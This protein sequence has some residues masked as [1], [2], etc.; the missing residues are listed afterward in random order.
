MRSR[1]LPAALTALV[2]AL[3]LA[4]AVPAT[5]APGKAEAVNA[6]SGKSGKKVTFKKADNG[7]AITSYKWLTKNKRRLDVS[8]KSKGLGNKTRK[9]RLL[10]PKGWKFK[11][12][13]TWPVVYLLHGGG[14]A[15][16]KSWTRS[17]QIATLAAKWNAIVVMPEG[18]NGSYTNWYNNGKGGP[19]EW[20]TFHM[21]EVFQL[22]NRNMHTG[23]RRAILGN[24]S[25][26]QGAMTYAA[27]Y[28]G[29]FKYV[30]A[31]SSLLSILSPGIPEALG[32]INSPR[33]D[34]K[35]IYGD[36]VDDR[37]NWEAHDPWSLA[38]KLRGTG[39]YFSTGS[40]MLLPSDA[41]LISEYF[42]GMSTMDFKKRLDSLGI[43]YQ[44]HI[45]S[46]GRHSWPFWKIE[47]K[48]SWPKAMKAIK[49]KK[50]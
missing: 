38:P 26:G 16:Y 49:A 39:I 34:P 44:A 13:K 25:G 28:P 48:R 17:S 42:V 18:A 43:K 27:R 11:T 7:S 40:G 22:M 12:K 35:R 45:Y 33:G 32:M 46:G 8:V 5:A 36:P 31:Y 19:P 47:L 2:L 21:T 41:G 50:Y 30:A 3:G 29:R 4:S 37:A 20:E 10:L 9:V 23:T 24:S 1:T 14:E 6:A 15:D